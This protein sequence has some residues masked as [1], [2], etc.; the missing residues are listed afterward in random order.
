MSFWGFQASID[1]ASCDIKS[2]TDPAH[3]AN[4]AKVLVE[5][6]K[7]VPYGDPQVVHF[8]KH[9]P[10]K[11]GWTLIQL[12]ETSNITAHFLD[13][14]GDAYIDVFSCMPYDI[15]IVTDTIKE[16]FNPTRVR[17]N[18]LTRQA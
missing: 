2:V 16:F 5:R 6:I 18:I 9:D 14:N 10:D 11:A 3:I 17:V 1:A 4:F 13:K 12:I 7:M 15:N 8:A